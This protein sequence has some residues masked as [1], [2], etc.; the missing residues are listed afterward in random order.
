MNR[1]I[2]K[3]L[4]LAILL[5]AVFAGSVF[6]VKKSDLLIGLI[7]EE[8]I[9]RQVEKYRPLE[10]Y[11]SE[12][13]GIKVKFTI[14]SKYGDVIDRFQ[15]LELDGAFFGAFTAVLANDKLGIEPLVQV[16]N[17]D[18]SNTVQGYIIAR[19][20][21]KIA[22]FNDIKGKRGVF[23]DKATASGYIFFLAYMK[24][25]GVLSIDS[26]LHEYYF[27]GSH[28]SIVLSVLD[29]RAD[30]GVLNSRIFNRIVAKDP[31]IKDEI[32]IVA[33]SAPVPSSI[34][35]LK[36]TFDPEMRKKIRA[37]MLGMHGDQRGAD[38]LKKIEAS[39]FIEASASDFSPVRHL[40]EEAGI[41]LTTYKYTR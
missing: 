2:N 27:S 7:P 10:Q 12:K 22:S 35:S 1:I 36:K 37:V 26:Y 19:K 13:L 25:S 31:T 8:N 24:E 9:F 23:V 16:V 11:L 30:I 21:S 29:G 39:R 17:L 40:M 38:I 33:K 4:I 5:S 18:G 6:G 32:V 14:L 41:N 20:D 3:S 28:D 34:F 15:T